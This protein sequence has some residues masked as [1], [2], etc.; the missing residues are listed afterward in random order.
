[1]RSLRYPMKRL[2]ESGCAE[3]TEALSIS[4]TSL[5]AVNSTPDSGLVMRMS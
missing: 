1:M 3:R 5:L 4:C 2:T